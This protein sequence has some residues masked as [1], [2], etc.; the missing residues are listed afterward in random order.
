[1]RIIYNKQIPLCSSFKN[2]GC[3]KA[4]NLCSADNAFALTNVTAYNT[5]GSVGDITKEML[6]STRFNFDTAKGVPLTLRAGDYNLD[7]FPDFLVPVRDTTT[8]VTRIDLWAS[9]SANGKRSYQRVT[10]GVS[11]LTNIA[12]AYAA[13]FFDFDENGNLDILVLSDSPLQVQAV[14]NNFVNDAFF[15][16]AMGLN[17]VC[18]AF[19]SPKP[20]GVNY[21]GGTFKFTVTDLS[22]GQ[23]PAVGAQMSQSAYLS[24]QT[25]YVMFG[26]GRISNYIEEF[27]YGIPL[28]QPTHF[29]YWTGSTIPNSQVVA[30]PCKPEDPLVWTLE[31]YTTPS[32]VMFWVIISFIASVIV[33]G[34]IILVLYRKEK[35][36]DERLKKNVA[37]LFSFD[38]L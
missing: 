16:K 23:H 2:S 14:Y 4:T 32:G 27:F 38:A 20:Y 25:P 36:E 17:G 3:R 19:G 7:G 13:A 10:D 30:I 21:V 22:G 31:L 6:G 5:D 37:H 8:N 29:A 18:P 34:A 26:L 28:N 1:V 35:K 9:Y 11:V 15:L 12:S 24:L 33:L